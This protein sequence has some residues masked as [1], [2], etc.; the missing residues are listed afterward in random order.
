MEPQE[1]K[2]NGGAQ[3]APPLDLS[4]LY[5]F[6][7][8]ELRSNV[9]LPDDVRVVHRL[10]KPSMKDHTE[11]E[12]AIKRVTEVNQASE[13]TGLVD[14]AKANEDFYN[15]LVLGAT[16]FYKD[17][18]GEPLTQE[19]NAEDCQ[20]RFTLEQK[21]KCIATLYRM[22]CEVETNNP[23]AILFEPD[24]ST[25]RVRQEL[26]DTEAPSYVIV[27]KLKSPSISQRNAFSV[28]S[29]KTKRKNERKKTTVTTTFNI[30]KGVRLF[31]Q[32]FEGVEGGMVNDKEYSSE[33]RAE[34]LKQIDPVFKNAVVD[35]A[36]EYFNKS[37]D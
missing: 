33:A 5:P 15:K 2:S 19:F 6:D 37:R 35:C 30:E 8:D 32:L 31:D 21:T 22:F 17:A 27:Y 20:R 23:L 28:G 25:M 4:K 18:T 16:A 36:V 26:G 13:I 3:V 7:A 24:G 1:S 29:V 14:E 11:R 10:A 9:E 34:F 12:Q